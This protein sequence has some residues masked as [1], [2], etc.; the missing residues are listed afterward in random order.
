M[1][2]K[3]SA[4][5]MPTSRASCWYFLGT[6]KLA[7]MIRKMN[8]LSIERLYSVSQPAIELDAVLTAV[9]HPHP[10]AERDGQ[11]DVEGERDRALLEGRLVRSARDED[12]VEQQN[13]QRH[14]NRDE[15]FDLGDLHAGTCLRT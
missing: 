15:P 2:R 6:L 11:T 8:R 13:G 5:M 9:R 14:A 10:D 3:I 12:D 1:P 4:R 7:M